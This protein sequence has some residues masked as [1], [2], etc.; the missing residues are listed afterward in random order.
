MINLYFYRENV[1][2]NRFIYENIKGNSLILV[3]EQFTLQAERDALFYMQKEG[4]LDIEITSPTTF[5]RKVGGRVGVPAQIIDS[6]GRHM[7]IARVLRS[8]SPDLKIFSGYENK[9]DFVGQLVELIEEFKEGDI[10]AD[11]L[12]ETAVQLNEIGRAHV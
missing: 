6:Q 1:N 5:A 7:L 2:V 11:K 8:I 10:S 12:A 4:L 9:A 3:P